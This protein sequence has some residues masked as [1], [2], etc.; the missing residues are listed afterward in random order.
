MTDHAVY[1]QPAFIIQ[2]RN[3]QE[4]SLILEVLTRDFGRISLLAKGVKKVKSKTAG[5]L[6][7]FIPLAISYVGKTDLKLLTGVEIIQPFQP[8]TGIALYCGFY[9][10]ELISRFLHPNDPH[11]DVFMA[12][13][14]CLSGL[15]E[16]VNAEAA[17]RI[18]ELNLMECSGYGLTLD[19]DL[20]H[21]K[22]IEALKKYQFDSESGLIEAV[23]GS[24]SGATL[25][26]LKRRQLTDTQTLREA[27]QLMRQV[28]DGHLQGRPLK[29]R[30]VIQKIIK[31]TAHSNESV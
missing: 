31:K 16:D 24:F 8:I 5:L 1:L 7:P 30:A 15:A 20:R 13:A 18:F 3:Y 4:T 6:Q 27:K 11:A 22:P 21:N 26:A 29:S 9:L 12:Y 19:Y 25:L 28:I 2:H 14:Q 17:L 23:D 10:N